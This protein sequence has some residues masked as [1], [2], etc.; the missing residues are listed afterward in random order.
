[1]KALS[2]EKTSKTKKETTRMTTIRYLLI[3][4]GIGFLTGALLILAWDLYGILKWRKKSPGE[5]LPPFRWPLARK[6]AL[7]SIV[8]WLAGLSIAV[9][10]AGTAGVRTNQFSG[11]RPGTLYPGVH[12]I[13]PT[14]ETVDL[15]PIRENVFTTVA[16]DDP[17]KPKQDSM[18]V[19]TREGLMVGLAITVRYRVDPSKLAY[20]HANLPTALE[21]EMIAPVVA[22]AFRDLAPSYLV[23]E[24]FSTR[25]D[26]FRQIAAGRIAGRLGTD[27]IVVKEVTLRDIQLPPEYAR[28]L[29]SLL[30]KEQENDRM[31]I[32]LE[33][34]KKLVTT[35]QLEAEAQ[36]AREIKSA[37]AR[38]EIVVLEAKA[39]ADAMQ[40]TLPLK[41]KQIEQSKLEAQARKEATVKNAEALAEA[42]VID[43]K[44]ELEKRK[45]MSDSDDYRIRRVAGADAERM[46]LEA[47]VLKDNPALIQ[48]II[49][50]KL[51]DK[52][53]IMMVPNDGK[54]FFA[55]DVL[56]G[57]TATGVVEH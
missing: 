5:L 2:D 18:R 37:E 1:L 52:V 7:L 31:N 53:Q 14:I 4:L 28:G 43:S 49:A 46:R 48:K 44:A 19:Q 8:P 10:P 42:K 47:G 33:V 21:E 9:V 27:G 54:F 40:H 39:Q 55:N 34:K 22:S 23:R 16:T 38:A 20:I 50:E 32:D 36:K 29:E 11:T 25:R 51:S 57:M 3:A 6:L 41:Q 24:L 56:K 45:L 30:L 15:Y 12:L 13:L 17:K 26:E 35:A